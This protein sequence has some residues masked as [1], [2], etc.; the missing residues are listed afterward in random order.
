MPSPLNED[1]R[2]RKSSYVE[3][4]LLD[5]RYGLRTLWRNPTFAVAVVL[6]LALGIGANTAIFTLLDRVALRALP[7][8]RPDQLYVLGPGAMMGSLSSDGIL[9]RNPS[10]FSYPLFQD[11]REH[12]EAFSGLAAFSSYP[13]NAYLSTDDAAPGAR[14]EKAEARLVSGEFFDVLGVRARLGRTLSP[15]DNLNPGA[16]P[17]AVVSH[18]FWERRL[19]R[20][21]NVVGRPVRLNGTVYTVLGVTPPEFSGIAVGRPTEIW[22]PLAMQ[23]QLERG[24]SFLED[25]N[26]MWLRILG[27]VRGGVS[28]EQASERT[29]DLYHRLLLEEAG[30]DVTPETREGIAR[31]TTE[32]VPFTKG[33]SRLRERYSK[34]LLLLMTVVGLVLLIACANVSNLLLAR[35]ASRQ[36]EVAVRLAVG[37]SRMR[38]LVQLLTESLILS[39]LGG[40]VGLVLAQWTTHLLL[41][42]ISAGGPA[43]VDVSL[44]HR[45]LAFTFGVSLLTALVFGLVPALRATRVDLNSTL[46]TQNVIPGGRRRSGR[47][48]ETLVISQVAVSLILLVGAGLFLRSLENLRSQEVGFRPGGVLLVDVDPQGGGYTTERL[49]G[50]YR[51]LVSRI[52]AV[53]GVESASLSYFSLMTGTRWVSVVSVDGFDPQSR[54]DRRIEATLVTPGYF[55]TIG[56]PVLVGRSLDERDREGAPSVAVVNQAFARH[57]FGEASPTGGRFGLGGEDSS[58]DIEIVGVVKDQKSHDLWQEAPRLVYFP[59]AQSPD[60]LSSIQVHTR[61]EL[62]VVAPQVRRVIAEAAPELPI[63]AVR[64]LS[65]QIERSL[66][67]ERLLG[68]LT[69]FFGLLALL[70]ASIGLYGVLAYSVSQRTGEIGIRMALGAPRLEVMWMVLRDAMGWVGVGVAIGL[71]VALGTGRL[72]SSLLFGLAPADPATILFATAALVLVASVAGYWPARRASRL[73]PVR[74]LRYE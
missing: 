31:L 58:R 61:G 13:V 14:L 56:A 67:Q 55:E 23:V 63:L 73:D 4:L 6:T 68:Q 57:F 49:L 11:F 22:I 66:R 50:L 27:R 47:L 54:D 36:R 62:A 5:A 42:V 2:G 65:E 45:V 29:N 8:E 32:L 52:E 44:D 51:D 64:T 21:Q 16:H 46:K 24:P 20:D 10:F 34:P 26:T 28:P 69:G 59:V 9:E 41:G 30:A 25:R 48:R 60:Y 39:L 33:L 12:T 18:A 71:V 70:L 53:P 74:A 38:L 17:V 3:T 7:V 15:E 35:A 72:V 19:G 40:G 1:G 43:P 37:A